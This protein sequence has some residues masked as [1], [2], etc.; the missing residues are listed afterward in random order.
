MNIFDCDIVFLDQETE[1][2]EKRIAEIIKNKEIKTVQTSKY[3][4]SD[5]LPLINKIFKERPDIDFRI[6]GFYEGGK[7]VCDIS[8]L[9]RLPAVRNLMI[10]SV[11]FIENIDVLKSLRLKCLH[12]EVFELKDFSVLQ[13]IDEGL[14]SLF[15]NNEKGG[16]AVFDCEW[17]LRFKSLREL[18][19]G[20]LKK[21]IELLAEIRSLNKLTLRGI[22][23]KSLDFL[24][25]SNVSDLA[26]HWCA[27]NDLSS[28]AQNDNILR[29]ELF[30]INKL[31]ELSF[32]GTLK[33]L[34]EFRL[35]WLSHVFSFPDIG[36]N[37]HLKKIYIDTLKNLWDVSAIANSQSVR[38]IEIICSSKVDLLPLKPLFESGQVTSRTVK[39]DKK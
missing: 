8:F 22:S 33:N 20:K 6:Y 9:E 38:N 18:Y 5:K 2:S 3:V 28:L 37:L 19:L 17:L 16:G 10:D 29:L 13:Y 31:E 36:N 1:L 12:L 27:M 32:I 25:K 11:F 21:N 30:R 39:W 23:L 26:V 35:I 24:R 34:E 7:S 14:E 4:S 15:L